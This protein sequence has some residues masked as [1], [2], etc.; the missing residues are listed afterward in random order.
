MK[1]IFLHIGQTKTAT[2]TLQAFF[3]ANR[4]WLLEHDVYYPEC[5]EAETNKTQHRFL[6]EALKELALPISQELT[7][8]TYIKNK[9]SAAPQN[10]ILI[11]EE[12]F[13]H[14][15]ERRRVEKINVL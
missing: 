3:Y 13:W 4:E 5:P 6:A 9:I 14:L 8:W 15:F 10:N 11:S 7:E 1:T 12:V 2:T